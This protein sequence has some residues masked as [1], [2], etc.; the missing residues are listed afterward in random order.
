MPVKN[1]NDSFR[2]NLDLF[3]DVN[4]PYIEESIELLRKD[5]GLRQKSQIKALKLLLCNMYLNPDREIMLSRKKQSLGGIKYN[6]LGIGYRGIVSSLDALSNHQLINQVIGIPGE[7][8]T[9]MQSTKKLNEWF[10]ENDWNAESINV[11]SG[12]YITLRK[13]NMIDGRATY[14][15]YEDTDYSIW[16]RAELKKYNNLLNKSHIFLEGLNGDKDKVF[17]HLTIQRKFI[18][19]PA[20]KIKN[21]EFIFSGRMPGPWVSLSQADRSRITINGEPTVELDR[22]ASHLNA[23]YQVVTGVPYPS[24]D[25][26]EIIINGFKIP[27]HII[28]K[29]SNFMQ[30]GRSAK[31]VAQSVI[32]AYKSDTDQSKYENYLEVRKTIKSSEIVQAILDK[33]PQIAPYYLNKKAYGDY[34]RCWESDIVFEVVIELTKREIPCLT[35]YDSFIVPLQYKQLVDKIKDIT[36]YVNRRRLDKVLL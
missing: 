10:V 34:I 26:Y 19:H 15:D 3:L 30:G 21:G 13:N 25:P 11:R 16:L 18:Q 4:L 8:L 32:N 7:T 27:R 31:G 28:K 36:P 17:S 24:G 23:M 5:I 6:P 14:I 9:T 20:S 22:Q 33:H 1:N 29:Y 2:I 35:V 12:Q